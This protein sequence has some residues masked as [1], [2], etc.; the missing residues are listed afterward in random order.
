MPKILIVDDEL[1]IMELAKLY[2]ERERYQVEGVA[3]GYDAL[4][5]LGSIN[6]D[7]NYS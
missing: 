7:L 6:P 3:N 1:N 2:L 5:R 4:S